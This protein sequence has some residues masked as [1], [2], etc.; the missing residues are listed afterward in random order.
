VNHINHRRQ[1]ACIS[2]SRLL[3]QSVTPS[4]SFISA[5]SPDHV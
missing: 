1:P 3:S 4:C 2:S 5:T